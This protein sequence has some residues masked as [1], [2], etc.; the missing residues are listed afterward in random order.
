[1]RLYR[2]VDFNLIKSVPIPC[3]VYR[4]HPGQFCQFYPKS[5]ETV[6]YNNKS[7]VT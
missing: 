3:E 7:L 4:P 5:T 1:M 6:E 2:I